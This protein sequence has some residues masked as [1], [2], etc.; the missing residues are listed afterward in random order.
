M[1]PSFGGLKRLYLRHFAKPPHDQSLFR[2][3]H[4]HAI[5]KLALLGMSD[6]E[7]T[8]RLIEV[9]QADNGGVGIELIGV[10]KFEMRS[11]AEGQGT[12]LK[13]AH[14]F[15]AAKAIKARLLPG[16]PQSV[17]TASANSITGVDLLLIAADQDRESLSR[18]W[19]YVPRILSATAEV[20]IEEPQGKA[21]EF[22][23]REIGRDE[24]TQLANKPRHRRAA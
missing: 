12:T 20:L 18:A 16:D 24:L 15:F 9:A 10:D 17:L 21:G 8:M 1:L 13:S 11:A 19:F 2:L 23:W 22:V 14:R 4:R 3:V 6:L 5:A 7:R